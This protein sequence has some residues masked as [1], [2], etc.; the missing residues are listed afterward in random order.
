M[1]PI[2]APSIPF[3][4]T[5]Q[6]PRERPNIRHP[7]STQEG[8]WGNSSLNHPVA[9]GAN[10]P[11][12]MKHQ[13]PAHLFVANY[14][15]QQQQH[16]PWVEEEVVY[17][18]Q[19]VHAE[20]RQLQQQQHASPA[21]HPHLLT[22]HS[23]APQAH[24]WNHYV[25][26]PRH[27]E[28]SQHQ[29]QS[30]STVPLP[31][32]VTPSHQYNTVAHAVPMPIQ[33]PQWRQQDRQHQ[34]HRGQMSW[35]PSSSTTAT[36]ADP[37]DDDDVP[38]D[39][40]SDSEDQQ[41]KIYEALEQFCASGDGDHDWLLPTAGAASQGGSDGKGNNDRRDEIMADVEHCGSGGDPF[42]PTPLPFGVDH[43]NCWSQNHH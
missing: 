23:Q 38:S 9:L 29:P 24:T 30:P 31:P 36:N 37:F 39:S 40:D 32:H 42:G 16:S 27:D 11:S 34:N 5:D 20:P 8:D 21:V 2:E 10:V 3:V 17:Y 22:V 41:R 1:V 15:S 35:P 7:S 28:A 14:Q 43:A 6:E 19:A 12:T 26:A 4:A 13:Q 33:L 18:S 25:P